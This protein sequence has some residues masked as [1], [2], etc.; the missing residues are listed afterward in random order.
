MRKTFLVFLIVLF[1]VILAAEVFEVGPNSQYT[2]I[3]EAINASANNDT[4]YVYNGTYTDSVNINGFGL[5]IQGESEENCIVTGNIFTN[6]GTIDTIYLKNMTVT[7]RI[8]GNN[9]PYCHLNLKNMILSGGVFLDTVNATITQC[10][11]IDSNI[12]FGLHITSCN[13]QIRNCEITGNNTGI[14]ALIYNNLHLW[15][16]TISNNSE[17]GIFSVSASNMVY[18][19]ENFPCIIE[20]NGEVDLYA[21]YTSP[22]TT[23]SVYT[24]SIP[25]VYPEGYWL[26]NPTNITEYEA[27]TISSI[28]NSPNPV[29]NYTNIMFSND[30]NLETDIELYNSRGQLVRTLTTINNNIKLDTK[31][32][33]S[34][35]Y[36]YKIKNIQVNQIR[37]M[38]I[39]K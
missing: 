11:I 37:K 10:Q 6:G 31:K 4:V 28:Y 7:G 13:I 9:E 25:I 14:Y 17:K 19:N 2:V 26:I 29:K 35:I 39:L 34:G 20:N 23:I 38:I 27:P 1:T 12:P 3:Q 16:T 30:N 33:C 36:F 8:S 5:T 21:V 15:N 22:N 24:T 18:F 32:H